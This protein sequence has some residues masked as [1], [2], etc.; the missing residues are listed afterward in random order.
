M[1]A[2]GDFAVLVQGPIAITLYALLAV[3]LAL[4]IRG[5]IVARTQAKVSEKEAVDA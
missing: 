4:A 3:V 2:N 5:R 1:S